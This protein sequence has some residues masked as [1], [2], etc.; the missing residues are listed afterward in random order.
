MIIISLLSLLSLVANGV[1]V[2]YI[3][4]LVQ[5]FKTA[6]KNVDI[7]Q[8][9]LDEYQT[10]LEVMYR[11]DEYYGDDTIKLTIQHTKMVSEACAAF[12]E[13]ILNIVE[14]KKD[15]VGPKEE[16]KKE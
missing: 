13:T 11:M 2:W 7:Y 5:Q 10:T 16:T 15:N 6:V 4:K 8:S 12:R 3:I 9:L 1:L 14:E